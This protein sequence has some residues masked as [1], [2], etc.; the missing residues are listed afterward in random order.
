MIIR[1]EDGSVTGIGPDGATPLRRAP[2][3]DLTPGMSDYTDEDIQRGKVAYRL[4][5]FRRDADVV[6]AILA[7]VLPEYR[8][9]VLRDLANEVDLSDLWEVD[10]VISFIRAHAEEGK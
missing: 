5:E 3:T 7:A 10:Q 4:G 8:Q 6:A 2:I 1:N 9:R